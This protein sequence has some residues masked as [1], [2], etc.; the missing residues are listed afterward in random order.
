M[1]EH[2][3]KPQEPLEEIL[4]DEQKATLA[5]WLDMGLVLDGYDDTL[6]NGIR[7][8]ALDPKT[9]ERWEIDFVRERS[10]QER[11]RDI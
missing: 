3:E 6:L 2:M 5:S 7:V 9:D 11:W 1:R 8:F 4:T 10:A